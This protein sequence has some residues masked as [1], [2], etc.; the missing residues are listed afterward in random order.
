MVQQSL[1]EEFSGGK[2]SSCDIFIDRHSYTR[3]SK[4]IISQSAG[5][6]MVFY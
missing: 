6:V 5:S 4:K 2:I 1:P 3:S